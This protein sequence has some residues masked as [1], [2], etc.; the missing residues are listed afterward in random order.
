MVTVVT[1]VTVVVVARE[2][3]LYG[4]QLEPLELEEVT[5]L[6]EMALERSLLGYQVPPPAP[7]AP[8]WPSP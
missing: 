5:G 6:E 1:V 3:A 7:P 2:R 8:R 4:V